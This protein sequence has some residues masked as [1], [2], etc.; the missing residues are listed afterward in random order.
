MAI[1]NEN[2]CRRQEESAQMLLA[3][4]EEGDREQ[5]RERN[6]EE[7]V[8]AV[9]EQTSQLPVERYSIG[10]ESREEED[11]GRQDG[12]EKEEEGTVGQQ[13]GSEE[14]EDA[15]VLEQRP[16]LPPVEVHDIAL[17]WREERAGEQEDG[18][19]EEED[20][21]VFEQPPSPSPPP[22]EQ[23]HWLCHL[24]MEEGRSWST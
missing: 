4:K 10:C 15:E 7:V 21:Q 18:R 3:M 11:G 5:E 9:D 17:S 13:E 2:Q 14:E 6:R 12:M 16:S 22:S 1:M 20:A 8:E 24:C 19:G 23:H